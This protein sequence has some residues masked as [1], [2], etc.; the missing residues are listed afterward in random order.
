MGSTRG[1]SVGDATVSADAAVDDVCT[2][3]DDATSVDL[4]HDGTG[5]VFCSS[6]YN[7]CHPWR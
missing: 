7:A 2:L 6:W 3:L 1:F 5:V 4:Y